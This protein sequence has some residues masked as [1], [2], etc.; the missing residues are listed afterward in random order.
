MPLAN[1]PAHQRAVMNEL[2][3]DSRTPEQRFLDEMRIE[4]E[5]K[6]NGGMLNLELSAGGGGRP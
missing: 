5:K 6:A 2:G 1:N 4:E 3:I